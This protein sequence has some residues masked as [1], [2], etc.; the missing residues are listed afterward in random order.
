MVE[1]KREIDGDSERH[2]NKAFLAGIIIL[3][4]NI[5]LKFIFIGN[6]SIW[7]DE[8]YSAH[9]SLQTIHEIINNS[10]KEQNPPL[11]YLLLHYW[12][13]LFPITEFGLRSLSTLFS[14]L[15]AF[16]LFLLVRK[17]LKTETAF[18]SALLFL[19]SLF[20]PLRFIPGP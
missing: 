12:V 3:F 20:A 19:Q 4:L 5:F 7:T 9:Q 8:A 13:K 1:L 17:F 18:F 14:A 2:L 10:S 15:T 11:Y 16:F 6:T